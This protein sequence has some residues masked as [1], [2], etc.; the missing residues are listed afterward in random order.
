MKKDNCFCICPLASGSKGNALLVSTPDTAILVDAGL[1]GVA[2]QRRMAA[3]GQD[4]ADLSAIIIT[5][6]HI[7]HVRGAGVLGRR[8]NI[9]V[10]ISP[11]THQA[12][13]G[14]GSVPELIY[15]DCGTRFDIQDLILNPFS[16]SHD[17]SDPAGLTLTW[18]SCKIGIAT[19]LGVVTNLVRTHLSGS[20][21]LYLESN[22]DPDM[23]INGAYPWHLKQRIQSRIGHL[24]N[25]DAGT[26]LAELHHDHL[27][28]VIL[29]HLSEENNRPERAL[30]EVG[31]RLNRPGICLS[32]A[33]PD[34]PGEVIRI[35]GKNE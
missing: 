11:A 24:S 18:Q 8:F 19:D 6:E 1:S 20:T 4:P 9:P 12:C 27:H 31:R 7:D 5:H 34:R 2:L 29:A 32:V 23:L 16:I 33:G 3:V 28:H 30:A 10:Y 15:F 21:L 17:A 14:L 25:Q 35:P 26:L 13:P 22:H